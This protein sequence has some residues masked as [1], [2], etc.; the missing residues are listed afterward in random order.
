MPRGILDRTAERTSDDEEIRV[1]QSDQALVA[2]TARLLRAEGNVSAAILLA[3]VRQ[4]RRPD[5]RKRWSGRWVLSVEKQTV[6]RVGYDVK[7]QLKRALNGVAGTHAGAV[8]VVL[9][10][11]RLVS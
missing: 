4:L 11:D 1:E 7:E 9:Y 6:A 2:E 8:D 10:D 5:P 3:S